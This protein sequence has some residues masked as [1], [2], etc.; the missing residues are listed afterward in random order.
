MRLCALAFGLAIALPAAAQEPASP[1]SA[2]NLLQVL[3]GLALV[4]VLVMAA[5]WMLRHVGRVPGLSSQ[6]IK[7]IGA[8]SVGTRERV[9]LIEVAGTWIVVGVAPGQVRSLATLPKAELPSAP[10]AGPG[11]PAF[12]QWLQR[13]K[14]RS[15]AS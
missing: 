10:L 9:V 2:G 14:D 12:A 15:H 11:A 4:L 8:A 7:M 13:F 1:M 3:A 5:A 6:A